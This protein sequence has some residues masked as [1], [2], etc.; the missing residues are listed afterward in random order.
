VGFDF[1]ETSTTLILI[2]VFCIFIYNA[3]ILGRFYASQR[4]RKRWK[5]ILSIDGYKLKHSD[6][7]MDKGMKCVICN[8]T[9]IKSL[10]LFEA[11]ATDRTSFCNH[12]GAQL[13]RTEQI[14]EKTV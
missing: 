6:C 7:V 11:D 10:G 12:C 2:F 1:M 14:D 3:H 5:S 13:Y 8:S 4:K 9:S